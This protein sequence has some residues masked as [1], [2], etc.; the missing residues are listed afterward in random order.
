MISLITSRD[1]YRAEVSAFDF[2]NIALAITHHTAPDESI[3]V[4]AHMKSFPYGKAPFW[5]LI[6]AVVTGVIITIIDGGQKKPAEI[7]LQMNYEPA[8]KVYNDVI[9]VFRE[10]YGVQVNVNVVSVNA[11]PQKVN[12]SFLADA[13]V[14]EIIEMETKALGIFTKGPIKDIGF[15]NL[16]PFLERDSLI[17]LFPQLRLKSLS[18]ADH[19]LA[20]PHDVH[21]TLWLYRKDILDSM[22]V[23]MDTVDTWPKFIA[24]GQRITRDSDGDGVNDKFMLDMQDWGDDWLRLIMMQMGG[25]YFD[26]LGTLTLN[27]ETNVKCIEMYTRMSSGKTRISFAAGWGQP[28][29]RA[30]TE[31][32]ILFVFAPDWRA[33][34]TKNDIPALSGKLGLARLPRFEGFGHIT[35]S[36]GGTGLFMTK[37]GMDALVQTKQGVMQKRELVWELMKYLYTDMGLIKKFYQMGRTIPAFKPGWDLPEVGDPDAYYGGLPAGKM[38]AEIADSVPF[39]YNNAYAKS[40]LDASS[41]VLIRGRSF[42]EKHGDNDGQQTLTQFIEGQLVI[43]ERKLQKIISRNAFYSKGR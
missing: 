28:Y 12:T 36:M 31:G 26:S 34:M 4:G 6:I 14:P 15:E 30:L 1:K 21:P 39:Y 29:A 19:I 5:L 25:H 16:R 40:A 13:A 27:T 33:F 18:V 8:V 32:K 43:E 37:K 10:K 24:L 7:T 23:S 11:Q 38:Y 3:K 35:S 42:Y 41:A 17:D 22:G 20:I 9:N 2:F